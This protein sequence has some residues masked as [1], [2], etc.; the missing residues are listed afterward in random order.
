[1]IVIPTQ[2]NKRKDKVIFWNDP[3]TN[4]EVDE[5]SS[6]YLQHIMDIVFRFQSNLENDFH[7]S[8]G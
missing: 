2:V 6:F 3:S 4:F 1:M 7:R 5:G 8:F